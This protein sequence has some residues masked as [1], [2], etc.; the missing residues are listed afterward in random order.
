[1]I[2]AGEPEPAGRDRRSRIAYEA[3]KSGVEVLRPLSDHCRYDLVFGIGSRLF[4]VQCKTAARRGVTLAVRLV[5]S[6]HTPGGYVRNRYGPDEFELVGAHCHEL[7]K[8][9]LLPS[10]LFSGKSAVQLRLTAPGN[11][12]KASLHFAADYEFPGAIAQLGERPAGSREVVGSSPT[13]ST[14]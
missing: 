9:Y 5:S 7:G 10:E 3:V 11:S 2:R 6:W 4:R 14:R 13:S 1:M 8:S 12:Q